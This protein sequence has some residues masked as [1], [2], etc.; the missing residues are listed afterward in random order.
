MNYF[1]EKH[2]YPKLG[3]FTRRKMADTVNSSGIL[4]IICIS[5]FYTFYMLEHLIRLKY[6]TLGLILKGLVTIL[7]ISRQSAGN[8]RILTYLKEEDPQRLFERHIVI[9]NYM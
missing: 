4:K 2:R 8:P 1:K 3:N 7:S 9:C 6:S 5:S